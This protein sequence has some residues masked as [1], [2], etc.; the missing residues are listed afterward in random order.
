MPKPR[1]MRKDNFLVVVKMGHHKFCAYH[2]SAT[3]GET[4]PG[5]K[6]CFPCIGTEVFKEKLLHQVLD[7]VKTFKNLE[8]GF[9]VDRPEYG[10]PY[11]PT[12][13]KECWN[14]PNKKG[15]G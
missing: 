7:K 13:C 15:G 8:Y 4:V 9:W 1:R 11:D 2:C 12:V 14:Y 5:F 3:I 6:E 10:T